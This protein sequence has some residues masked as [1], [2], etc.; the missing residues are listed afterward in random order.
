MTHPGYKEIIVDLNK[1]EQQEIL[2]GGIYEGGFW[3]FGV[4]LD[5]I[6]YCKQCY[7]NLWAYIKEE[8]GVSKQEKTKLFKTNMEQINKFYKYETEKHP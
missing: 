7:K 1:T 5:D 2:I 6:S 3:R 8:L 4:Y